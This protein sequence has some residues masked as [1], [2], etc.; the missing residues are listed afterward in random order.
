MTS[1]LSGED[2]K[3]VA[4]KSDIK[5]AVDLA[6]QGVDLHPGDL[7]T[8]RHYLSSTPRMHAPFLLQFQGK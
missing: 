4:Q 3:A 6:F 5:I 7:L 2:D 1:S 8:D